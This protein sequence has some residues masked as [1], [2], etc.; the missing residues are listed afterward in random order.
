MCLAAVV[1]LLGRA[2]SQCVVADITAGGAH[3]CAHS[4][5]GETRCWGYND[6][7][8]LGQGDINNRGTSP[9]Q[10]GTALPAINFGTGVEVQNARAG[11]SSVCAMNASGVLCWGYGYYGT[12]GHGDRLQLGDAAGE[13][14]NLQI[15]PFP[16][17]CTV[18]DMESHAYHSCIVCTNNAVYC[19]G[20]NHKGQLGLGNSVN[21]GDMAGWEVGW[22]ATDVGGSVQSLFKGSHGSHNC[23]I[24]LST[25][26]HCWGQG[27]EGQLGTG[28]SVNIGDTTNEMGSNL[29]AV[30]LQGGDEVLKG[31]VGGEYTCAVYTTGSMECWGSNDKGQLG[32]GSTNYLF[33]PSGVPIDLSNAFG[34]NKVA[35]IGCGVDHVCAVS[36]T[37]RQVACWGNNNFGQLGYDDTVVRGDAVAEMTNLAAL[38]IPE[39]VGGKRVLEIATATYHTC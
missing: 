34:A 33:K 39:V 31:C 21:L 23:A 1:V 28:A 26:V 19:W 4:T 16:S 36:D 5:N 17:A 32:K 6:R 8:Q 10:M 7:G 30:K 35:Q 29:I 25:V 3:T 13:M 14:V 24:V 38:N 27:I 37:G 11:K 9:L 22:P 18:R 12:L 2:Q 20:R 15:M